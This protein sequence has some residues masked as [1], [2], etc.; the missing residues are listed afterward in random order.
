MSSFSCM[1]GEAEMSMTPK[2]I[3][4]DFGPTK[5]IKVTEETIHNHFGKYYIRNS[6]SQKLSTLELFLERRVPN[7]REILL[8]IS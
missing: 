8:M 1:L 6:K 3:I 5:L 7:I 4:L 2:T